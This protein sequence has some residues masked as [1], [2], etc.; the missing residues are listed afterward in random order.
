MKDYTGRPDIT[1]GELGFPVYL[2]TQDRDGFPV[3]FGPPAPGLEAVYHNCRT[4]LEDAPAADACTAA[5]STMLSTEPGQ[6]NGHYYKDGRPAVPGHLRH[7]AGHGG[8]RPAPHHQERT[9]HAAARLAQ[10]PADPALHHAPLARAQSGGA[11]R[12]LQRPAA[13]PRAL[14]G[15]VARARDRAAPAAAAGRPWCGT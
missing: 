11:D 1:L 7:G 8:R 2:C 15:Q 4:R 10:Q 3:F 13:A 5:L 14:A 12:L 6:V 9:V